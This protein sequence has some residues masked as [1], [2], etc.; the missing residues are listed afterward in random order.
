MSGERKGGRARIARG[1]HDFFAAALGGGG[2]DRGLRLYAAAGADEPA[3][4][5][6]RARRSSSASRRWRSNGPGSRRRPVFSAEK[7]KRP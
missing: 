6:E 2:G 5:I 1:V 4:A 7:P 3:G